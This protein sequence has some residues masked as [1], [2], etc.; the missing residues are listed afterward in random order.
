MFCHKCG[1]QVA[2]GAGFCHKCGTRV[3]RIESPPPKQERAA[4]GQAPPPPPNAG[5]PPQGEPLYDVIL[6]H[7][8][9]RS[10]NAIKAVRTCT[11]IGIQEAKDLVDHAP[12]FLKKSATRA[13]GEMILASLQ[14]VGLAVEL[15]VPNS[16]TA[17]EPPNR[18][19]QESPTSSAEDDWWSKASAGKKALAVIGVIAAIGLLLL[20][21]KEFGAIIIGILIAAG[22]IITLVTGSREEKQEVRILL[23]KL[24]GGAIIVIAI[25]VVAAKNP[26]LVF[27]IIRP[28]T[29]VRDGYLTHFS[30]DV[31]VGEAFDNFF[32]NEKWKTYDSEG[33]SYVAFTGTCT[34]LDE[35][36]DMRI[37]FK[38]TGENFV[39]DHIDLDGQEQNV[40][41]EAIIMGKIYEDYE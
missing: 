5:F 27:N 13:G 29:T 28:G 33:Y 36:A 24:L 1:A 11:G 31:T 19:A 3:V 18:P 41:M 21:L 6:V 25:I 7:G 2:E 14:R 12:S 30:E 9:D 23:A 38:I 15:A 32:A 34:Y 39:L 4:T 16:R 37:V 8:G 26:N 40:L 10:I 22:M 35:P 17:Y 20:I